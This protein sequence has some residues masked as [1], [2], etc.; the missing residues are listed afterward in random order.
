M[1]NIIPD[2][3]RRRYLVK[4]GLVVA[5]VLVAT[6]TLG[7][8][9]QQQVS[10]ELTH[11]V[12]AE[13]ETIASVEA[14]EIH[15][16]V[17]VHEQETRMLSEFQELRSGDLAAISNR[18]SHEREALGGET[19][20]IHY[21]DLE[22]GEVLASTD[23]AEVG[24]TLSERDL[25]WAHGSLS[26]DDSEVA[27]SEGYEHD[28]HELVAFVSPIEGGTK[29][30]MMTADVTVLADRFR[31]PIEGGYTQVVN[32]EGTV[33][34]ARNQSVALTEYR[35][36]ADSVAL[37]AGLSGEYGAIERDET[38]EVVAYAPVEGTDWVLL[39]HAPQAN[40]YAL[41]STVTQDFAVLI[42]ASL[43][44]F[45]VIGLTIGR[46]TVTALTRIRDNAEAIAQ[47]K[48]DVEVTDSKRIDEVGQALTAFDDTV[49]YLRTVSAQAT[50]LAD[51]EFDA[52]ALDEDVPGAIGEAIRQM[53]HDLEAFIT[54]LEA[55]KENAEE[56]RERA[57]AL[58]AMLERKAEEFGAVM[59][60]AADGDLTARLDEDVDNEGL[61]DIAVAFNDMLSDLE[62]TL[63]TVQEVSEESAVVSE[64]VT[65]SAEE[66]KAASE[67]VSTN[68][69]E[70]AEGASRQDE[71]IR[72]AA[73][74]MTDMSATIE[75]I[76]SSSDEVAAVTDEA[77]A[78]GSEGREYAGKTV[79]KMDEIEETATEAIAEVE[80]LDSEVEEISEVVGLI[81]DIAEQTN[82]L[83]LNASIE[84]AAA[85]QAGDGFAVVAD[86]VKHLAEET[87]ESTKDIEAR[88]DTVQASTSETVE[89]MREM[90]ERVEEGMETVDQAISTLEAI[91]DKVEDANASVQSINDAT[92][93]QA[94]STE[95]VVSMVEDV[96]RVSEETLA[97]S[98]SVSASAEEQTASITEVTNSIEQLS[99]Q[100]QRLNALLA[101]FAVSTDSTDELDHDLDLDA[102][103]S[104]TAGKVAD[105]DD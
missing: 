69:Q 90:G 57:E 40:A 80:R 12:H 31:D 28:G 24:S 51:Q 32:S 48:T 62:A 35:D 68:V 26:F 76:A 18:L 22:S 70:I 81:D 43:V 101:E 21:V 44:G 65:A 5:V 94:T 13:M 15:E 36:G 92:D 14:E 52:D 41:R 56:S 87:R 39:A 71:S 98:Q 17:E 3:L 47:G 11:D 66:V 103:D 63:L 89:N 73:N 37:T 23:D 4:F 60:T 85:D 93:E 79:T 97:Q 78:L 91:V 19:Q 42:V 75:E 25:Q 58:T 33:E 7:F 53:H 49:A 64:E 1:R 34:I 29:A 88:I 8:V 83:A 9:F 45:A 61:T 82:I 54:D 100:S 38:G 27:V 20:A 72:Q 6:A 105:D 30:V 84:A 77:A 59:E 2:I 96:G 74:E 67:D 104:G 46:N 86:E 95:E 50:A 55:A 16:W 99:E 102:E 10:A